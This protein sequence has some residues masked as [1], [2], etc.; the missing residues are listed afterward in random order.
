MHFS[1]VSPVHDVLLVLN[2]FFPLFFATCVQKVELR[3]T[4]QGD[5]KRTQSLFPGLGEEGWEAANRR[6]MQHLS[7]VLWT[8]CICNPEEAGACN[9]ILY[10]T[11]KYV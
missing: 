3:N 1:L 4:G 6:L 8:Y 11:F 7:G 9:W 2:F 10:G 5:V